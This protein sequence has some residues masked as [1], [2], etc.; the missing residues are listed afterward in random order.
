CEKRGSNQALLQAKEKIAP[1][2]APGSLVIS[3]QV[4]ATGMQA[5]RR[6]M[7]NPAVR[8]AVERLHQD[9]TSTGDRLLLVSAYKTVHDTLHDLQL[10]CY[11]Q[12]AAEIAGFPDDDVAYDNIE[13][14]FLN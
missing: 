12:L 8:A 3:T 10:Q 9:I 5:L 13:N 4:L 14:H 7:D 2:L 1:L 6:L 11:D